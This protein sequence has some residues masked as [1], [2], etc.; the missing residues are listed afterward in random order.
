MPPSTK[1]P[2]TTSALKR[3]ALDFRHAIAMAMAVMSPAAAIFFNTIP[4][5]GF[6]GAAIPLCYGV[7]FLV[8]LLVANQF[9]QLAAELPTSGSWYTFVAQ[10]LGPHC[11][12]IAGWLA[13]IFYG[14]MPTVA[15]WII[16][17][18][19]HDLIRRW[20]G[21]DLPWTTWFI[22][23]AIGVFALCYLGIRS[24]LQ[25]DALFLIFEVGICLLLAVAVFSQLGRD[26]QLSLAPFSLSALP[27]DANLFQG[28]ILAIL[29]F[30]GFEAASTLGE[31][32]KNPRRTLPRAILGSVILVG[33]FYM[34]MSYVATVGYGIQDMAKFAEDAAPFDTLARRYGGPALVILVD[35]AG[36]VSLYAVAV[37]A[38]NGGSRIIYAIS[39]EGLFFRWLA[40]V[41]PRYQTPAHAIAA[42]GGLT[43]SVGLALGTWLSPVQAFSL[44]GAMGALTALI[45]YALVSLACLRYFWVKRRDRFDWLRTGLLPLVSIGAIGVVGIGTIYPLGPPPH[46]WVPFVVVGWIGI[47]IG[48]LLLLQRTRPEAIRRAG[49]LFVSGDDSQ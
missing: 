5:A 38:V 9:C 48:V 2:L 36:I 46:S 40:Q 3:D 33:L 1:L 8:S 22:L 41:H 19:L 12:F 37:A 35:A 17:F 30:T 31:E 10:G 26:G 44:L 14:L 43:L 47:G 39:R 49:A 28:V 24:S 13:L 42:L 7:A 27:S 15:F 21:L 4:Q 18:N 6:V 45:I 25:L 16:G 29:S 23:A 11:G 32:T 20:F 34:L